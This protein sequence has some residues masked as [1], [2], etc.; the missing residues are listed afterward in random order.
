[1]S[2]L[3]TITLDT[4]RTLEKK[5]LSGNVLV[6]EDIDAGAS[7]HVSVQMAGGSRSL[8]RLF[9]NKGDEIRVG[10]AGFERIYLTYEAQAG[11]TAKLASYTNDEEFVFKPAELATVDK[12][13]EAVEV[14]NKAATVLGVEDTAVAAALADIEA[15]LDLIELNTDNISDIEALLQNPVAMK[16]GLTSIRS[17]RSFGYVAAGA[18]STLV[19]AG[20]NTNGIY[21]PIGQISAKMNANSGSVTAAVRVDGGAIIYLETANAGSTGHTEIFRDLFVEA[22]QSLSI[23]T[24]G[25]A[26]SS[27]FVNLVY[28]VL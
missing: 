15:V 25:S 5:D 13:N 17:G 22:G 20:A 28:E 23:E 18:S 19:T 10:G 2:G 8:A 9:Q 16:N 27:T 26:I 3:E 14:V 12:I 6:L 4:K 11:K 1:M 7:L 21:I 24:G